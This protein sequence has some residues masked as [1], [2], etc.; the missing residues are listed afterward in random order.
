MSL[1]YATPKVGSSA[2]DRVNH[3]NRIWCRDRLDIN[4]REGLPILFGKGFG[5]WTKSGADSQNW[6]RTL[7]GRR[8]ATRKPARR[9]TQGGD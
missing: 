3:I 8:F 4:V 5:Q 6:A 7:G 1:L 2:L 9:Q